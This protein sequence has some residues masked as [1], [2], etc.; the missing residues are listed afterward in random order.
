MQTSNDKKITKQYLKPYI[1]NIVLYFVLMCMATAFSIAS[2]LSISN[3]LQI[4]FGTELQQTANPS[5][6]ENILNS[7]YSYFIAFGKEKALW[8]FAGLIFGIYFLKD[9]FTYFANYF[10]V[11]TRAKIVRNMRNDLIKCYTSQSIAFV[12]RYKKGD[13]LSRLS[14]DLVEYDQ[15]VLQGMQSLVSV[16]INVVLYFAVLLYMNFSL[17]LTSLI[18]VPLI[19]AV[20]SFISRKLR[21]SSKQ[22]QSE[23]AELISRLEET[24][25]GL[26]IIKSHTAIDFV[27]KGFAKFNESYTRLRTKIYRRVDLASPQSEFFGNCMVIGIL[28]LGTTYIISTPPQM[29][30]DF[31]I[32]YLIIFTLIIKP[33]KDFSTSLYN[34][35]KGQAAEYRIA[36]IIC[37]ERIAEDQHSVGKIEG[38]VNSIEINDLSFAYEQTEVLKNINLKFEK[39]KPTAVV[40]PS[41]AGKSTLIDLLLKFYSPTKGNITY[42]S[43]SVFDLSGIEIRNHIAIVSQDTILFNDTIID[44]L[45]FGKENCTEEDVIG[46]AKMAKADEFISEME[47]GYRTRLGDGGNTLSGGQKQRLSI[48]RAILKDADVL[49]LDEATSALDTV[50]EK[51]IQQAIDELSKDKIIISV[52]HRL[53]SIKH[54]PNIVV[55]NDGS[56][57][58]KGNHQELIELNGLYASLCSMQQMKS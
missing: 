45:K 5:E 8:I 34:I 7:I 31:F 1:G 43:T 42:N 40:G 48:A 21:K 37:A 46:A 58:E 9:L 51:Y 20:V 53:S 17:T 16:V 19:G 28:L 54:F 57:V 23:S 35:K 52:A 33:A 4:L 29:S 27:C 22:M 44:N 6:L 12:N 39:G 10:I 11:S 38:R 14:T 56:I 15:N 49:I 13:L 26:R 3:F 47:N 25:S 36:E 50:S 32:V 18:V 2:I 30:A 24:I 55:L 41:G